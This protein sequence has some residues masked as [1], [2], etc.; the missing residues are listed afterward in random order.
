[1]YACTCVGTHVC[2]YACMYVCTYVSAECGPAYM[3]VSLPKYGGEPTYMV[4]SLPICWKVAQQNSHAE[5]LK[6]QSTIL[7]QMIEAGVDDSVLPELTAQLEEARLT[8]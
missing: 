7:M 2:M 5:R 8:Q 6:Q 4:V 1:M 3:V